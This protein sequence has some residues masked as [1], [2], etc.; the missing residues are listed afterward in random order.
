MTTSDAVPGP[1]LWSAGWAVRAGLAVVLAVAGLTAT[2]TS[3][4]SAEV[5]SRP[6]DGVFQLTGHGFG[7]GRGMPQWGAQGAAL[8]GLSAAQI[9][10][11]YYRGTSLVQ[12]GNPIVR[13]SLSADPARLRVSP[14]TGLTVVTAAG[15]RTVLPAGPTQ[16]QIVAAGSGLQLQ[17]LTD[18]WAPYAVDGATALASPV[19][20]ESSDPVLRLWRSDGTSTDYR[21]TLGAVA[22]AGQV[23][24]V[25]TLP[26]E[27]YLRGVVPR[28]SPAWFAAAALEAQAV[29]A[30]TYAYAKVR[31][32][33]GGGT[34]DLCDTTSCQVFAGTTAYSTAGAPT[35]LESA[36][37]D[38]AVQATAG[39]TLSYGGAPI[40]AEYSSSSGGW[41]AQGSQPYLAAVEDPYDP[42][43]P[44]N[45]HVTWHA[46]L[47]ASVIEGRYPSIGVLQRLVV[48]SRNGYGDWG[49]RVLQVRFEGSS[50]SA[51]ATGEEVRFLRP[52]PANPD[53]LRS[54]WFV[55]DNADPSAVPPRL[56]ANE[57]VS[58]PS[59]AYR[60]VMQGDGNLVVYS[61]SGQ[62]LWATMT[63]TPGS[64]LAV[65]GDG[66]VV[67][68][69]P[70]GSPV[71]ATMTFRPGSYLKMQDDG[72]LVLYGPSGA[73]WDSRGFTGARSY[74]LAPKGG[75]SALAAGES[76][77]SSNGALLLAMQPDGNLVT[78]N[79]KGV[80][81]W[82][83]M[84]FTP[85]SRM[86][87]QPDGNLVVYRPSGR[88]AWAAMVSSPGD[89]LVLQDDGNAVLYSASG[90]ALWDSLG[91]TGRGG[92]TFP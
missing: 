8:R 37:T 26:M 78:Y 28:E 59:G 13:V 57:A 27:S 14:A 42:V 63:F 49:G 69:G 41:T 23:A 51:T 55:V 15:S 82:A 20:F 34:S 60:L 43:A 85:G 50:G 17:A 29:A 88:P 47:P 72:N 35:A 91:F 21:G 71:W 12:S 44:Q 19:T 79:G 66:N 1:R 2:A 33:A 92:V 84:T 22:S 3:A 89:S 74:Y 56:G 36:S 32:V 80:A 4:W 16:W 90:V 9:L 54:S 58:S 52:Y 18:S 6:A 75:I 46:A 25:D 5:Y 61:S 48:V 39:V 11:Y 7:H 65:Q 86:V 83:T 31:A 53:G 76:A 67:I 40:V 73:L 45:L 30:R 87:V 38:S 77:R 68:Y 81:T 62:P 70:N 10:G 24:T 64:F